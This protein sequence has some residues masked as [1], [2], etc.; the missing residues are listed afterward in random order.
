MAEAEASYRIVD[1]F[2]DRPLSGNAVCVVTDPVPEPLMQ[3]LALEVNLS[4]T[5]FVTLT[6]DHTYDVRI[7]TPANELPFAG[8]PTLGTA[9][10]LGPGTWTQRSP[11][12]TVE[13]E[14]DERGATFAQPDPK[15]TEV[16]PEEVAAAL[17]LL[18]TDASVAF[19]IDAGGT[20][21]VIVPTDHPLGSIRFNRERMVSVARSFGA[22]GVAAMRATG[23]AS[24]QVRLVVPAGAGYE[25]PGTGSAAG[26]VGLI[27]RDR[28]GLDEDIV[29][30][31][32][33][34]IGRPCRIRVH[35]ERGNVRVG[36]DVAACAAGVFA[37][38][39]E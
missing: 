15:I 26:A 33:D 12:L 27:A 5:T 37:L 30:S 35:A 14:T 19:L 18:D 7:F 34:E 36:G 6:G 31:Q 10:A 3:P 29:I 9:W 17:G 13:V 22:T 23:K 1:V 38:P 24:V 2:T 4:E 21:H 32:G 28:W 39:S 16:Y 20:K 25:D 8:H 11:G